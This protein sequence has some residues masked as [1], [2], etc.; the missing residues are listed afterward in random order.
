MIRH[1][2]GPGILTAFLLSF[3]SIH[4]NIATG[5][6][7]LQPELEDVLRVLRVLGAKRRDVLMKHVT[8]RAQRG[9]QRE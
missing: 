3:S 7:S 9:M 8:G 6:A 2:L 1:R 5:L 4:V